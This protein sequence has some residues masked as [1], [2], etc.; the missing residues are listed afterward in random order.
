MDFFFKNAIR[1][2]IVIGIINLLIAFWQ[3]FFAYHHFIKHEYG[4]FSFSIFLMSAN[5]WV[6]W[7]Q[8]HSIQVYKQNE[9]DKMWD[10][11]SGN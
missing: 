5:I 2:F 9:K 11:L 8:Y 10:I 6:A 4:H 1:T 7:F 3:A